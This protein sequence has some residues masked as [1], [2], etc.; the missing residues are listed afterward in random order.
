[1]ASR[2][3]LY[4]G[5]RTVVIGCARAD[6]LFPDPPYVLP[7]STSPTARFDHWMIMRRLHCSRYHSCCCGR[8]AC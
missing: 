1:M 5:L 6:V 7:A 8:A 2:P 3:Q 4:G